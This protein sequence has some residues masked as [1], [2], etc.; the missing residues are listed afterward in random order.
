MSLSKREAAYLCFVWAI[1][2]LLGLSIGFNIPF[3]LFVI[4]TILYILV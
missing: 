3:L 2:I 1:G 4:G